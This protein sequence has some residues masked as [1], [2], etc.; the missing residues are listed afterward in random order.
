MS[1]DDNIIGREI[2]TPIAFVIDRVS[3][4]GTFGGSGCQFI[5]CLGGEVGI[6]GATEYP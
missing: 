4:E 3:K 1:G 5:K 6:A 2:E